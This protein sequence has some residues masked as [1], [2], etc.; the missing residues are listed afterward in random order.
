MHLLEVQLH[1]I[2]HPPVL[3]K[4]TA[5]LSRGFGAQETMTQIWFLLGQVTLAA[6]TRDNSTTGSCR[7]SAWNS[8]SSWLSEQLQ[9]LGRCWG[10]TERVADPGLT[11][12]KPPLWSEAGSS[13]S[14]PSLCP[15]LS[16]PPL[17]QRLQF[18]FIS[19]NYVQLTLLIPVPTLSLMLW[20]S[21]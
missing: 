6:Q 20:C 12:C 4:W 3:Q 7:R 5:A 11:Q 10:C 16:Q 21:H 15:C 14:H 2:F 19:A 8:L 9:G 1:S 18:S 17:S 13:V